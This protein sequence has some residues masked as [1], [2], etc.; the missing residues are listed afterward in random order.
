[1]R[2]AMTDRSSL[3]AMGSFRNA[4]RRELAVALSPRAQA[5]W[6]RVVKWAI[7]LTLCVYCWRARNFWWWVAGAFGLAVTLHLVWRV[8]THRWTRPW[9][10]WNDVAAAE[11]VSKRIP[12]TT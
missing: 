8:K 12:P 3:S 4:M 1:M 6:F 7:T 5:G 9:G 11:Q 10:G 2:I